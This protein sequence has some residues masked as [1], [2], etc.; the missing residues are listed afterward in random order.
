LNKSI[1]SK[2]IPSNRYSSGFLN[3]AVDYDK[4]PYYLN[5]L[6]RLDLKFSNM[7][8]IHCN[9]EI[10]YDKYYMCHFG[11]HLGILQYTSK[12]F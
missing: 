11:R 3:D 12:S 9:I 6:Y 8:Y 10:I 5:F 2:G 4:I 7:E 1:D